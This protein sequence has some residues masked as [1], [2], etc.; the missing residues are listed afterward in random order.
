MANSPVMT[1]DRKPRK[2]SV[3]RA[4]QP[5][6]TSASD[7]SVIKNGNV[8]SRLVWVHPWL[9]VGALWLTFIVMIAIALIGLSNPGRE[10]VLDPIST[11]GPPLS[12]PDA[13]AAS[14]LSPGNGMTEFNQ[15]DPAAIVPRDA[16]AKDMP[17]WPLL[18]MVLACAGGCMLMSHHGLLV[19]NQSRRSQRRGMPGSTPG[20]I[21]STTIGSSGRQ[22]RKQRR[23]TG[24]RP[25]SQ[26]MAFRTGQKL[27]HTHPQ[28][29]PV[30][31]K[32]VS[33]SVNSEPVKS[34]TVVPAEESSPLDW[35]EGS[36]A[37]RLDVRQ[38]RSVNSFLG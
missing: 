2:Q 27:Q 38:K 24:Y 12:A 5:T 36:L 9:L 20:P 6:R 7:K 28:A 29:R 13:A 25:T 34:V 21:R 15:R 33:F 30:V 8:W 32:P 10:I 23:L 18:M 16:T 11:A 17:A 3:S 26:V 4:S 22:R 14:R 19:T 1:A 35:K 37:H 31:S